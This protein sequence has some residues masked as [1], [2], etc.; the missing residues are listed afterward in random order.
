MQDSLKSSAGAAGALHRSHYCPGALLLTYPSCCGC[1]CQRLITSPS[2]LMVLD[3]WQRPPL[4]NTGIVLSND[5]QEQSSLPLF[6][7]VQVT[8]CSTFLST[9]CFRTEISLGSASTFAL[10]CVPSLIPLRLFQ[11]STCTRIFVSTSAL[12]NMS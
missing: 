5:C 1:P 2:L 8:L 11:Y 9:S 4:P 7:M 12:G 10:D 3:I 6:C